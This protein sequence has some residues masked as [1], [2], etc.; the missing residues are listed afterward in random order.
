MCCDSRWIIFQHLNFPTYWISW[1]NRF[2]LQQGAPCW[3][4]N[5]THKVIG[6][7]PHT[8][9]RVCSFSCFFFLK[10][11]GHKECVWNL[12]LHFYYLFSKL[13]QTHISAVVQDV[14]LQHAQH[15]WLHTE[16]DILSWPSTPLIRNYVSW[17]VTWRFLIS[18]ERNWNLV[19]LNA[20]PSP[21]NS[22]FSARA[23][24]RWIPKTEVKPAFFLTS[25]RTLLLYFVHF[26]WTH[27]TNQMISGAGSFFSI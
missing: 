8:F 20:H 13:L 23:D 4:N 21:T 18:W 12:I 24:H 14:T 10:E 19:S 27:L 9:Y 7:K 15:Q 25:S 22:L 11:T 1:W 5:V 2:L 17:T 16:S 3:C 6:L 26:N